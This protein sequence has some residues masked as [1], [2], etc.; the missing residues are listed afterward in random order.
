[1]PIYAIPNDN[2]RVKALSQPKP[3]AMATYSSKKSKI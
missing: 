3:L 1:M 2:Q